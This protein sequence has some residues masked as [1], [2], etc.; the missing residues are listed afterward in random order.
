MLKVHK[1]TSLQL[2][3]GDFVKVFKHLARMQLDMPDS[4][5]W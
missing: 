4:I 1:I 5:C 2:Q 3:R